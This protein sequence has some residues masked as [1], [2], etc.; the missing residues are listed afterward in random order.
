MSLV[1]VGISGIII[2]IYHVYTVM[3]YG[4]IYGVFSGVYY[5]AGGKGIYQWVQLHIPSA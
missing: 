2:S 4:S 1:D 5:L 3:I